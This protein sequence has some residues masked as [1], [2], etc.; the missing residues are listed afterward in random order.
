MSESKGLVL[1]TGING[2]IA[3]ATAKWF[4][5]A[6]YNVRGTARNRQS[7]LELL[8]EVFS[9][10]IESGRF[11]V[12]EV[13]DMTVPGA[14]DEAV[15]GVSAIAHL[16]API[17][18]SFTEAEPVI[19][20]ATQ[21]LLTVFQSAL[22]FAGPQMKVAIT[23]SSVASIASKKEPPYMFTEK[24]WNNPAVEA[25]KEQGDAAGG[26]VIYQASKTL[27]EKAFWEFKEKNKPNW[28]FVAVNPG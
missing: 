14:F 19:H 1:V 5:D 23:M 4:L 26:P 25:I 17:S 12:V 10:H 7:S 13:K 15:K 28:A 8:H 16:A 3:S 2:Y 27:A 11:E 22:K 9:E 21:G 20:A 24:D 18:F 6:G